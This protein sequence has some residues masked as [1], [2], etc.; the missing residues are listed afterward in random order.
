MALLFVARLQ[1]RTKSVAFSF[2]NNCKLHFTLE[3]IKNPGALL[4]I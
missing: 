3:E 2:A 4:V 1:K